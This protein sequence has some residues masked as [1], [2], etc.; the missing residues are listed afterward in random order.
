MPSTPYQRSLL[1]GL[2]GAILLLSFF[3]IRPLLTAILAGI[4]LSYLFYPL[5]AFLLKHQL[6]KCCPKS[7]KLARLIVVLFIVVVLLAPI[8]TLLLMIFMN[9]HRIT[10]L[11]NEFFQQLSAVSLYLINFIDQG[12]FQGLTASI[13]TSETVN[14]LYLGLFR[15]LQTIVAQIPQFILGSFIALFITYYLLKDASRIASWMVELLPLKKNHIDLIVRRFN[16]LSRGMIASQGIIALVQAGLMLIACAILQLPNFMLF[17][18]L[19]LVFAVIPFMGAIVVWA[20]IAIFLF[21]SYSNG[22]GPLWKPVFMLLYG[23]L[24]I[25]TIDNFIR[26]KILAD[27]A[28]INPAIILVG[29]IGGFM[30]FGIPGVFLGPMIL[31]LIELAIEVYKEVA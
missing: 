10:L 16:G 11:L 3:I 27:A 28:E 18:L 24:L 20:S 19:T 23:S 22:L 15:M 4:I 31:G 12:P 2:V 9:M 8:L 5:Y 13:N 14:A 1:L 25:S 29:F 26:P 21:V 30:L 7:E 17:F 6:I